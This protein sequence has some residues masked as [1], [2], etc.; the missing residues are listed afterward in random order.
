MTLFIGRS[1]RRFVERQFRILCLNEAILEP[2]EK[3]EESIEE[4]QD[5]EL[6]LDEPA[7]GA[8]DE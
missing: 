5:A 6:T 1:F 7:E 4:T 2:A 8:T 3:K